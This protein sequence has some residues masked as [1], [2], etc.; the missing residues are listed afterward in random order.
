M[1]F[2][3]VDSQ[4]NKYAAAKIFNKVHAY[5][6][7]K[8]VIAGRKTFN[9]PLWKKIILED[10]CARFKKGENL[11]AGYVKEHDMKRWQAA[12]HVFGSYGTMINTANLFDSR[13]Q[14]V[15]SDN[16]LCT[17]K[18][19]R[20]ILKKESKKYYDKGVNIPRKLQCQIQQYFIGAQKELKEEL[21]IKLNE[22]SEETYKGYLKAEMTAK[23]LLAERAKIT[24]V[25]FDKLKGPA[26]LSGVQFPLKDNAPLTPPEDTQNI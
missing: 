25:K 16:L 9:Y 12:A 24:Q 20:E 7:R 10:T 8:V 14:H 21:G 3:I 22:K 15:H 23:E 4:N 26:V 1:S 11:T 13:G 5:A 18:E 17:D 2:R 19:T 6:P